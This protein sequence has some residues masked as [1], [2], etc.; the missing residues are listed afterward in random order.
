MIESF[1]YIYGQENGS[2]TK[3]IFFNWATNIFIPHIEE[4]Y[5]QMLESEEW[6][7]FLV[8]R[9]NFRDFIPS[10]VVF[11]KKGNTFGF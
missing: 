8:D 6:V 10:I 2:I 4:K 9:H 1:Y 5:I 7:L 3:Q 11:E